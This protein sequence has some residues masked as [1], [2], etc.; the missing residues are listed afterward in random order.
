M[1]QQ[2]QVKVAH[3]GA[4]NEKRHAED[5]FARKTERYSNASEALECLMQD[6]HCRDE[7]PDKGLFS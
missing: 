1:I 4:N 6:A 2:L 5:A 7:R 3:A